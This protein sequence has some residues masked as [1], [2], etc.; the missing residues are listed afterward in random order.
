VQLEYLKE[1][2]GLENGAEKTRYFYMHGTY[3]EISN[4]ITLNAN[5]H[6]LNNF[7]HFF[8]IRLSLCFVTAASLLLDYIFL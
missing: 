3:I 8:L 7:K 4:A 1:Q 6:M 5:V 2:N